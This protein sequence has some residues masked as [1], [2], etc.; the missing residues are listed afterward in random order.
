MFHMNLMKAC[1]KR[2]PF[3]R[4]LILS[5]LSFVFLHFKKNLKIAEW[6]PEQFIFWNGNQSFIVER[7]SSIS[8]Q[9][10]QFIRYE[11]SLSSRKDCVIFFVISFF[12]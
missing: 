3:D 10:K 11:C 9:Y 12:F 7:N 5:S 8:S 1:K 2:Y 4:M 6:L